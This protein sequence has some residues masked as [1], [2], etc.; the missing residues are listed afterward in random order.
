MS[1]RTRTDVG[2][3]RCLECNGA[4]DLIDDNGVVTPEEGDRWERYEC[5]ECGETREVT[6]RA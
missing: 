3:L 6:L 2:V 5:V 4:L 1:V